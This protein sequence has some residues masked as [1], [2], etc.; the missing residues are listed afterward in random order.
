MDE[1]GKC[2][3]QRVSSPFTSLFQRKPTEIDAR[4]LTSLI[5]DYQMIRECGG[6]ED[7]SYLFIA[8]H[9][10]SDQLVGLKLTDLTLSNDY[11]LLQEVIVKV[12]N[13]E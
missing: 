6:V 12:E 7:I 11:E 3:E 10:P 9:I 8:K 2:R 1:Q 4:Q 13:N 5:T